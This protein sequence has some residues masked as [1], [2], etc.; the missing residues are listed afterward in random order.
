MVR[1]ESA[2]SNTRALVVCAWLTASAAMRA[3][4]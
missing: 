3:D 4:S 1:A 2:N